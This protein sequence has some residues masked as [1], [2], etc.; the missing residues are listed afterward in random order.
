MPDIVLFILIVLLVI[1][2]FAL[3]THFMENCGNEPPLF[4]IPGFLCAISIWW[5]VEYCYSPVI[6]E[7]E[8]IFVSQ[9]IN[10]KDVIIIDESEILNLNSRFGRD[11]EDGTQI[12]KIVYK[13]WYWTD[14]FV[15]CT[16]TRNDH[17]EVIENGL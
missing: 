13:S 3:F 12:K 15:F 11:F 9:T 6:V 7:K 5:F 4:V 17:Y 10:N 1:T 8:R 2:T 14:K 16:T